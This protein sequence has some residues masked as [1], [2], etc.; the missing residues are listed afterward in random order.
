MTFSFEVVHRSEENRARLGRVRTL[1]GTVETPAFMP[2]GTQATVKSL[3]P[4]ELSHL[5]VQ[6][7]LANTYHLYLRPG[8]PVVSKLGGLHR[9]MHWD[10]PI[11][12]DSGGYQ[13]FSLSRLRQI[14]EEGVTFQSHLDGSKHLLT[15][16]KAVEIQEALGSD[17]MMCLDE[18]TPYP[19]THDEAE[20]SLAL[21]TGW[22]RR[23]KVS[24]DTDRAALFG[25]VQGG[26]FQDLRTKAV[27]AL[28]DIGFDGY[29]LGGLSVGEAKEVMWEVAAF[30]LPLLPEA[31]PR[32]VMGV[33]TPED[34]VELVS[35][36]ADMFD[37]VVPTRN[38]R[39]GQL[40]VR[41]GTVNISNAR[42]RDDE[43]PVEP[44]CSCYT[45]RHYTRAYLRHLFLARELLAYRLN[46]IHNIHYFMCLMKEMREAIRESRFDGFKKAFF[47]HRS[48]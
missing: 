34:L 46:T 27:E 14:A 16:E 3:T 35:L 10:G 12:T 25:I 19:A 7:V 45:C 36:G 8:H 47:S 24:R 1:H 37:C 40:F 18:C 22:A 48:R 20:K 39:N 15:P 38:A 9:F 41:S 42:Y 43:G 33:G 44:G 23:C 32:Y 31:L 28:T 17:I 13:V 6:I 5:G 11:L 21:S 26:M 29:A 4:E 30:S 2:V